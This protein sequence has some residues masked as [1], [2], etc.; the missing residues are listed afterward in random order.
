MLVVQHTV[1]SGMSTSSSKYTLQH[2]YT[3]DHVDIAT[4]STRYLYSTALIDLMITCKPQVH[5]YD[6]GMQAHV[7][8]PVQRNESTTQRIFG[9]MKQSTFYIV[10]SSTL[11]SAHTTPS[12]AHANLY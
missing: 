5:S 4:G 8:C 7:Q 1:V 2:L 6:S 12:T 9:G 10:H 3:P 11:P